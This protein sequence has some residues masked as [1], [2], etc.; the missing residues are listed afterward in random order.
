MRLNHLKLPSSSSSGILTRMMNTTRPY[1]ETKC[2]YSFLS[3]SKVGEQIETVG[4]LIFKML[5]LSNLFG[6][7]RSYVGA[8]RMFSDIYGN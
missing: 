2:I 6:P 3:D 1:L 4:M 8:S 7:Y 5:I